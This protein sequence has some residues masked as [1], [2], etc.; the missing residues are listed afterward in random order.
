MTLQRETGYFCIHQTLLFL[1]EAIPTPKVP[2]GELWARCSSPPPFLSCFQKRAEGQTHLLS[3]MLLYLKVVKAR[4]AA[5][6]TLTLFVW[7]AFGA[8]HGFSIEEFSSQFCTHSLSTCIFWLCSRDA[9]MHRTSYSLCA[10]YFT[11]GE[12]GETDKEE[13]TAHVINALT[14]E[15]MRRK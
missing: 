1:T 11:D 9:Q 4:S 8:A 6:K 14:G 12:I 13:M 5:I 15:H 3:L 7:N 2:N 10:F